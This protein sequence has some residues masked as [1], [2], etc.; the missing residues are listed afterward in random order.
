MQPHLDFSTQSPEHRIVR[1]ALTHLGDA[2]TE[3]SRGLPCIARANLWTKQQKVTRIE[4]LQSEAR[5]MEDPPEFFGQ[6][7]LV[8]SAQAQHTADIE[9]HA[10]HARD[11][12]NGCC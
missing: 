5:V 10:R 7:G 2:L 11:E 8:I 12:I 3:K 6:R 1:I 4:L 9:M